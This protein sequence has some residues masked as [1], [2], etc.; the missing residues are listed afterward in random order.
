MTQMLGQF[1]ASVRDGADDGA[2]CPRR[3]LRSIFLLRTPQID[4]SNLQ[5]GK[6]FPLPLER[7]AASLAP[8]AQSSLEESF[9]VGFFFVCCF[10]FPCCSSHAINLRARLDFTCRTNELWG[11]CV[12][13]EYTD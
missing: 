12:E 11:L 9:F 1:G 5:S 7:V 10:F 13:L 3:M 8:V 4:E 6:Q 2:A